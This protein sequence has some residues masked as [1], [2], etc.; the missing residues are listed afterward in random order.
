M[1]III[2]LIYIAFIIITMYLV[3]RDRK[4]PKITKEVT[5]KA[6]INSK[7][8]KLT[9]IVGICTYVIYNIIGCLLKTDILI[10]VTVRKSGGSISFVGIILW[11]VTTL[12]IR[13]IIKIMKTI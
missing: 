13:F 11:V 3:V 9:I 12:L 8:D 7:T 10:P 5:K 6:M 4:H 1:Y 2:G